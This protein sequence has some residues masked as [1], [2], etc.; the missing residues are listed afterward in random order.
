MR[1]YFYLENGVTLIKII[2]NRKPGPNTKTRSGTWIV[3]EVFDG[4][5]IIP[6]FPEITL[7]QLNNLVYIGSKKKDA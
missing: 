2:S 4:Q 3:H 6:C 5:W 1:E 7:G